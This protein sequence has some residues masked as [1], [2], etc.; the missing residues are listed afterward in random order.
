MYAFERA[1]RLGVD[2]LE[3][4]IHGTQDGHLVV[5]HDDSV[6]RT[7]NGRG[8]IKEMTLAQVQALDAGWYWP[9]R[10]KEGDPRPFR[11]QG[12]RIPALEEVFKAFPGFP[13][14][15]EIKQAVPSIAEPFC[16]ML[17][18]YNMTQKTIVASFSDLAMRDFR[19]A[20]PEVATSMTENELRPM[21]ILDLFLLGDFFTAPGQALQVPM[22]AAGIELAKPNLVNLATR[23]NL[24]F[25]VWT[26]NDEPTMRKL[27][28]LGV[29]GIITDRPD[30]MLKL[31]GR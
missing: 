21:V 10:A 29:H 5:I 27:I 7:T 26:I 3:L 4:D 24:S 11:G 1:V 8:K 18:Q 6:D 19:K 23:K 2:M 25:Q 9:Q 13:M 15:I 14:T 30:L 17:R 20:C 31:L 12:I 16:K 28:E 22:A